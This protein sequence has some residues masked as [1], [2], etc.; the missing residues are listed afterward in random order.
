MRSKWGAGGRLFF[1]LTERPSVRI[2]DTVT[3]V[4]KVQQDYLSERYGVEA[5]YVPPG[6]DDPVVRAPDLIR[7]LGLKGNDYILFASRLVREKGAHYLID[8]YR[9]LKTEKK[10]VI[11][12]DVANEDAYKNELKELALRSRRECALYRIRVARN[13]PGVLQQCI[14]VRP[15]L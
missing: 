2:A 10:L 13:A 3:V 15:S 12:G 6:I 11:V 9:R 14:S 8:A 5:A 4:S 1:K 7:P